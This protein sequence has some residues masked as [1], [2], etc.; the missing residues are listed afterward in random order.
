M[1]DEWISKQPDPE[2]AVE[3]ATAMHAIPRMVEP[4]DIAAAT[5]FLLS[6][7]SRFITGTT[8]PVDAGALARIP[9]AK[10]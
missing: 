10:V 5:A 8:L 7:E 9:N 2:L 3:Q 4:E 1:V 6:N